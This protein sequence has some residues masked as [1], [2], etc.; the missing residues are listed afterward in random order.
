MELRAK[1]E[2]LGINLIIADMPGYDKAEADLVMNM[3]LAT[4]ELSEATNA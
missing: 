2:Q 3:R 1:I 4:D